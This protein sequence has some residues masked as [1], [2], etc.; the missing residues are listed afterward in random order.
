MTFTIPLSL[1]VIVSLSALLFFAVT[2]FA[3][4]SGL[5]DGGSSGYAGGMDGLFLIILYAVLWAIPS[6]AGWAIYATWFATGSP[7]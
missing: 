7:R 6:L 4:H 1:F 5:F 2:V 3:W